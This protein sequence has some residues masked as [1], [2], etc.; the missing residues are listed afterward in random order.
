[1]RCHYLTILLGLES[2]TNSDYSSFPRHTLHLGIKTHHPH[3]CPECC[4][5][6]QG[7]IFL[8]STVRWFFRRPWRSVKRRQKNDCKGFHLS[9]QLRSVFPQWILYFSFAWLCLSLLNFFFIFSTVALSVMQ[10]DPSPRPSSF[11]LRSDKHLTSESH[12][13]TPQF[14]PVLSLS[15]PIRRDCCVIV[16]TRSSHLSSL[17]PLN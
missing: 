14:L 16:W 13:I 2:L 8:R 15:N 6:L 4:K 3:A 1:M 12:C 7:H 5:A 11:R 9:P 10:F 17:L